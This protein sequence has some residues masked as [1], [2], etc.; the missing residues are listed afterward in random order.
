[1][2]VK[3]NSKVRC[4]KCG[5]VIESTHVHELKYCKCGT[6]SVDGGNCYLLFGWPYGPPDDW[7]EVLQDPREGIE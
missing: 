4:K 3:G 1:M 7:V 6:I 2:V 5:D